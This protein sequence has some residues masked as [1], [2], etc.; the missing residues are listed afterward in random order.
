M[1]WYRSQAAV[2]YIHERSC[3]TMAGRTACVG[4]RIMGGV[5]RKVLVGRESRE[6]ERKVPKERKSVQKAL[7]HG[8]QESLAEGTKGTAERDKMVNHERWQ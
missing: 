8:G 2:K 7:G 4:G 6:R 1:G 5:A 3:R